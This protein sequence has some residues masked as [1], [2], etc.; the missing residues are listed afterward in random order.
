MFR[1]HRRSLPA[2]LLVVLLILPG[3]SPQPIPQDQV[4]YFRALVNTQYWTATAMSVHLVDNNNEEHVYLGTA[5]AVN[6]GYISFQDFSVTRG[7]SDQPTA[8]Y[9]SAKVSDGIGGGIAVSIPA[10]AANMAALQGALLKMES[11]EQRTQRLEEARVKE[12]AARLKQQTALLQQAVKDATTLQQKGRFRDAIARLDTVRNNQSWSSNQEALYKQLVK[13][14]VS[15]IVRL[16]RVEND[17]FRNITFIYS[18][19]DQAGK[20]FR[21][22]PYLG[23]DA[24]GSWWFLDLTLV[25][26]DWLFANQVMV[27][28]GDSTFSTVV[29]ESFSDDVTTDVLSGGSVYESVTFRQADEG[30]EELF[31]AVANYSG[32]SPLK[33]RINGS[34]YYDEFSLSLADVQAWR[35]LLFLYEHLD[36]YTFSN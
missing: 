29:K 8:A 19:R 36:K 13:S 32:T 28:V 14:E 18:G 3:C 22:Y 30:T 10:N 33:V 17:E 34:E 23:K 27:K 1:H 7:T 25:R 4:D 9:I 35:D 26:D 16:C 5:G 31:R 20:G 6:E 2:L 12:E 21:F 24:S 15:R 11:N